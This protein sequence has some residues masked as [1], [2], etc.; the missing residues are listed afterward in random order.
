MKAAFHIL[1]ILVAGGAAYFSL[2]HSEKFTE[3]Q[4]IRLKAIADNKSVSASADGTEQ[5]L[6]QAN[7][8]LAKTKDEQAVLT[9]SIAALKSN[10]STLKRS[11]GELDGTLDEQK[12]QFAELERTLE[13]VKK[14]IESMGENADDIDIDS[15]AGK[16]EAIEEEKK[17][18]EKKLE[19]LEA[20]VDGA[21]KSLSRNRAESERLVNRK[22]ARA[23]RISR[24]AM[25]AVIT[26]VDQDWGFVVIGAGSNTGFTP[27]TRLLVKRD[28]RLIGR[29]R[30]TSIEPTQTIADIE[31]DTLAVGA[32]LQPG[33]RVI[34]AKPETN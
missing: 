30:P 15:L 7:E 1:A 13:E 4:E 2:A 21:G 29:V 26:A 12:A 17:A 10:E 28:G 18:N 6:K 19:D 5:E 33:D 22:V 27:Q 14:I 32:R 16:I 23:S 3:Q 9:Q 20:L 24:N 25:E 8:L 11:L 31:F 34:L